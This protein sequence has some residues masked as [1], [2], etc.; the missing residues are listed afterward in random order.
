MPKT[1]ELFKKINSLYFSGRWEIK[2]LLSLDSDMKYLT[3]LCI[4]H[5]F[6]KQ[7]IKEAEKL[8][9]LCQFLKE[10]CIILIE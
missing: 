6:G 5:F 1:Q 3:K 8:A 9:I 4:L 2:N 7:F 10:G